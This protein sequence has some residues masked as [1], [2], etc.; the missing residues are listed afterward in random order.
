VGPGDVFDPQALRASGVVAK[1]IA[2]ADANEFYVSCERVF[3]ASL[4]RRVIFV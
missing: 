1:V 4:G 3:D 2:I